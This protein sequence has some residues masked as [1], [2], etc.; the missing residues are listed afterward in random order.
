[1]VRRPSLLVEVP[2]PGAPGAGLVRVTYAPTGACAQVLRAS[3]AQAAPGMVGR[4]FAICA[5]AQQLASWLALCAAQG[6][7]P[8]PGPL[9]A[10]RRAASLEA[11]RESALHV[12]LVWPRLLGEPV[13]REAVQAL[14]AASRGE[15]EGK[16]LARILAETVYAADPAAWLAGHEGG[17]CAGGWIFGRE[18]Q[19]ARL[20]A[21]ALEDRDLPIHPRPAEGGPLARAAS[22]G[23][24]ADLE[25]GSLAAHHA[26]RLVELAR[27]TASFAR[28]EP[29]L[30]PV[31]F[32]RAGKGCGQARVACARGDLVHAVRLV[33]GTIADY[34]VVSPTDEAFAL[35]GH[36]RLWIQAVADGTGGRTSE[37]REAAL[38]EVLAAIDPCLDYRIEVEAPGAPAQLEGAQ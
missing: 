3:P 18:T 32:G 5:H 12:L 26:A 36:G 1:M 6:V 17:A 14:M 19:A 7:E 11:L 35:F 30:A 9:L 37:A 8:E 33:D 27:L 28:G 10:M 22:S 25:A 23:F 20:L 15:G 34:E 24:L 2:A 16:A 31:A 4:I 29:C 38:R 21:R 13:Q